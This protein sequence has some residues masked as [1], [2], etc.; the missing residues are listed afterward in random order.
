MTT[1]ASPA[2]PSSRFVDP[3]RSHPARIARIVEEIPGVR[4]YELVP[5][6]LE[7]RGRWGFAAGQFNMLCLPGIGEAAISISSDGAEPAAIGHTVRACGNVTD[8]L[9]RLGPGDTILIRGPF[10]RPWPDRELAGRDVVIVAGGLGLASQRSAVLR[11]ARDRAGHGAVTLLQGAKRPDALL[12]AAEH[13]AWRRAGIDVVPI[14]DVAGPDWTGRTGLVT[15]PLLDM[16]LDPAR[17]SVLC[18]GPDPM[19]AAVAGAAL[20]RGVPATA[21]F[22]S[23][24]RNM[25]CGF[26]HCGLC[27]LG[28][29]FV[30]HDG[31]V[32]R[33]DRVAGLLAVPRL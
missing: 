1:A 26:G 28:P 4:T 32:F 30:C 19:I 9:A 18:C 10:G 7:F 24:E 2:A 25:A 8:A 13:A 31:P 16:P 23:L 15:A 29:F 3:W 21:I 5:E 33:W 12:Y 22:V 27:Q 17:T 6:E 14:V 11:L 20:G